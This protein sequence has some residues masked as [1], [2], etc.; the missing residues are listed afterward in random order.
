MK[1]IEIDISDVRDW[2]DFH[3]LFAKTFNFPDYYGRNMNAWID[4][5]E[6]FALEYVCLN[7]KVIGM[8]ELKLS[9]KDIHDALVD[10]T[11]YVNFRVFELKSD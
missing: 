8:Q 1:H 7:L 2:N 11:A 10:C 9:N 4:C 5:M 3:D 6:E